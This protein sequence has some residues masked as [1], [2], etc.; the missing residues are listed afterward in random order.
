MELRHTVFKSGVVLETAGRKHLGGSVRT[1]CNVFG[2]MGI[3]A[4]GD[5][6]TPKL[7]VA[8]NDIRAGI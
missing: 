3:G 2:S 8:L 5:D 4:D 7:P 1:S 6:L